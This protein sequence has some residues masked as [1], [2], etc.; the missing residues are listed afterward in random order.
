MKTNTTRTLVSALIAIAASCLLAGAASAQTGKKF[1]LRVGNSLGFGG[2]PKVEGATTFRGQTFNKYAGEMDVGIG[3]G[4]H[5]EFMAP[6]HRYVL[7]GG[8]IGYSN[9]KFADLKDVDRAHFIDIDVSAK[10]R[11]LFWNERAEVYVRLPIG[12]TVSVAPD[13]LPAGYDGV[14]TA[15]F[16]V[17][18]MAGIQALFTRQVGAYFEMGVSH[19]SVT[20]ESEAKTPAGEYVN[21]LDIGT[22]QFAM[23]IGVVVG[24]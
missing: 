1:Q 21:T 8:T 3:I 12:L 24:F 2:S 20:L 6:V 18:A 5:V 15:G 4:A 13:G 17:S 9:L 10:A 11:Y 16:N 19:R 23:N 7:I 14:T 22:T